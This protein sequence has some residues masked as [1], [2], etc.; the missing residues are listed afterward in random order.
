MIANS[1]SRE[2]SVRKLE[3]PNCLKEQVRRR[4]V[5]KELLCEE[6][7]PPLN[8]EEV[9]FDFREPWVNCG[10]D[11]VSTLRRWPESYEQPDFAWEYTLINSLYYDILHDD[12]TVIYGVCHWCVNE[13]IKRMRNNA[14]QIGVIIIRKYLNEDWSYGCELVNEIKSWRYW[15]SQCWI[16]NL[17]YISPAGWKIRE[18]FGAGNL[19]IQEDR[20]TFVDGKWR[21]TSN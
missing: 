12:A 13:H 2:S 16:R 11:I 3:L 21:N 9:W 19:L 5:Y 17:F 18:F 10:I 1:I 6:K 15:C 8:R 7:L 20:L 14:L 4:Y